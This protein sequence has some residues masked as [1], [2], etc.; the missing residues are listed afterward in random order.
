M[1]RKR[2]AI[3]VVT[4]AILALALSA[5]TTP[6]AVRDAGTPRQ[7][8]GGAP[9]VTVRVMYRE[10]VLPGCRVELRLPLAPDSIPAAVA[11]TGGEGVAAFTPSPGRYILVAQW[12]RD[13]DYSRPIAPGDRFAYFGGNPVYAAP[14]RAGS[15][16]GSVPEIVLTLEEFRAP[17][18]ETAPPGLPTGISGTV[19]SGG[20]PLAGALV[21]ALLRADA[22]IRQ[23]GFATSAPTGPAGDFLLELPPGR[24]YLVARKR[25][26]GGA[27]GPLRKNDFFGYYAA[28]PV[29]VDP[30]R[31]VNV[32]IPATLLKLRNSPSY[33]GDFAAAATIEGRIVGRDGKPRRGVYAALYDNPNLLDRPVFM[34]DVTGDD[35]LYRLPVPT[36]GT[37]YLGAREGYGGS[38]APGSLYGRYEGNAGHAV[39]VREGD[40]LTGFDIVVEV[41]R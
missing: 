10:A 17:L 7:S 9:A 22:G 37:Y 38:P 41:V 2:L 18:P 24:Y 23:M 35:G 11:V 20:V 40:R 39:S 14:G 21:S 31:T 6:R 12:R 28:N 27:A 26:A 16:P 4:A 19:L 36:A 13:G 34:S 30:G 5:C 8:S 32:V 3:R 15:T 29:T 33:S 1:T 25:A